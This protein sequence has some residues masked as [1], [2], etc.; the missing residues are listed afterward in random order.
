[1]IEI[2]DKSFKTKKSAEDFIR[3]ILY[4]YPV[5]T[6]LTGE[7]LAFICD[8]LLYHPDKDLK[9]GVGVKSIIVEKDT[10]FR[11]TTHFS[12]VRIDNSK[13]DFSFGKCLTPNL[14]KAIKLFRTCARR[15]V[16]HQILLFRD[17]FFLENQNSNGYVKCQLTNILID[18]NNCHVDHIPPNTFDKIIS[19]FISLNNIDV[20]SVEFAKASNGI[21]KVFV[22]SSLIEAFAD[23][24]NEHAKLRV[25]SPI[26]NLKQKK[27]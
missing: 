11:T 26:A 15:V 6:A 20:D 19:D 23:Y 24:H 4:K 1:M 2:G 8:L 22:D 21:G 9:I 3:A 16:A 25:V 14:N 5:N 12:I 7:D 17:D 10:T 13:E 27:K 18:K